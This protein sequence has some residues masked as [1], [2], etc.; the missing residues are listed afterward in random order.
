[1]FSVIFPAAV[2]VQIWVFCGGG[3]NFVFLAVSVIIVHS[4]VGLPADPAM[5]WW[6]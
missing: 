4:G 6:W 3:G 5:V 1:L 2:L